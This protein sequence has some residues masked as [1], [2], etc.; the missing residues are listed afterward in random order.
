MIERIRKA[1]DGEIYG[2]SFFSY[3][4]SNYQLAP[5]SKTLWKALIQVETLTADL[6]ENTLNKHQV[7]Y[8]R[9]NLVMINKGSKDAQEWVHLPWGELIETLLS[10]VEPYEKKYRY[11]EDEARNET[12]TFQL[13]AAHETTIYECWQAEEIGMSGVPILL[14]FIKK[15][16]QK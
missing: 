4:A 10:W 7:Q 2:I 1:Y 6:L 15:Y 12:E 14:E 8:D 9:N 3:F 13:I 16:N 11:W 5:S